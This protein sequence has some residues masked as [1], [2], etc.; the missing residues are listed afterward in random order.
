MQPGALQ[1][2]PEAADSSPLRTALRHPSTARLH[3]PTKPASALRLAGSLSIWRGS[4]ICR[5]EM[6]RPPSVPPLSSLLTE[7]FPLPCRRPSGDRRPPSHARLNSHKKMSRP[8]SRPIKIPLPTALTSTYLAA[9]LLISAVGAIHIIKGV[10]VAHFTRD[11][12]AIARLPF[13]TGALSTTGILLWSAA[14]SICFF[15]SAALRLLK[16]DP[17]IRSFIVWSGALTFVLMIDDAFMIHENAP[18]LFGVSNNVLF[19]AYGILTFHVLYN[20]RRV[21][22]NTQYITLSL[23]LL[24][25]GTSV[26][27]DKLHDYR[28]LQH[29]G[30]ESADMRYLL[31]DGFKLLG[32]AG[33]LLYYGWTCLTLVAQEG[34]KRDTHL[35]MDRSSS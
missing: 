12:A 24:L 28:I 1:S 10:P 27:I 4:R 21:I 3:P 18:K 6:P 23:S 20:N 29:V 31:E 35:A 22:L 2:H 14:A 15:T 7:S 9:L 8:S 34:S 17:A 32:I 26:L 19:L 30:M 16:A 25:L 33:W 11:T 5:C 13:Y